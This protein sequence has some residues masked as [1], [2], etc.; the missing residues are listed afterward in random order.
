[1]AQPVSLVV[2][3]FI[4]QQGDDAAPQCVKVELSSEADLFFH[5]AHSTD[6]ATFQV[7][8]NI[9]CFYF[10]VISKL[11]GRAHVPVG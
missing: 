10:H 2:G 11:Y 8:R 4:Y 5:Y 7:M 3:G 1:M 6:E 9:L